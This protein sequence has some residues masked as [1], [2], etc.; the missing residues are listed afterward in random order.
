MNTN[1]LDKPITS[2]NSSLVNVKQEIE[3]EEERKK[4]EEKQIK[5]SNNLI[6]NEKILELEKKIIYVQETIEKTEETFENYY[7]KLKKLGDENRKI[8]NIMKKNESEDVSFQK[9]IDSQTKPLSRAFEVY[10]L[11]FRYFKFMIKN[12]DSRYQRTILNQL[13]V[14]YGEKLIPTSFNLYCEYLNNNS[15]KENEGDDLKILINKLKNIK[16]N[17]E[18]NL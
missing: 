17:K 3:I 7:S 16:E 10:E 6:I 5:L 4:R 1:V 18:K 14:D 12:F 13:I 8:L 9:Y 11:T 2:I 15:G